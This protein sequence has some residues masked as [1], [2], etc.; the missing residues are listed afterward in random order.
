MFFLCR[1]GVSRVGPFCA[2]S[3]AWDKLKAEGEVDVFKAVK[4]IRNNRPELVDNMV[5]FY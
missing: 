4:T 5:N 3:V 1:N 2:I